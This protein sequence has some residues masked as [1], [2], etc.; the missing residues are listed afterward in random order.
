[1]TI[2]NLINE[3]K[4]YF[5]DVQL[6]S[7]L[8]QAVV[9][10]T[11]TDFESSKKALAVQQVNGRLDEAYQFAIAK[12]V[13]TFI[14]E[15][16]DEEATSYIAQVEITDNDAATNLEEIN[17]SVETTSEVEEV[18]ASAKKGPKGPYFDHVGREYHSLKR[19]CDDYGVTPYIYKKRLE[20]GWSLEATLT[21]PLKTKETFVT[22]DA[23]DDVSENLE[24][25]SDAKV[26]VENSI[27]ADTFPEIPNDLTGEGAENAIEMEAASSV[28]VASEEE[29]SVKIPEDHSNDE[30]IASTEEVPNAED[31]AEE[32]EGAIP[33]SNSDDDDFVMD[34]IVGHAPFKVSESIEKIKKGNTQELK[35]FEMIK[36]SNLALERRG[37]QSPIYTQTKAYLR[38]AKNH[39]VEV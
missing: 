32:T 31:S 8:N 34:A 4:K 17:V 28:E 10:A 5:I 27:N 13:A 22:E 38:Y 29:V 19:M 15:A 1:M 7:A 3:S 35:L 39:G 36:K 11:C 26:A 37:V 25:F 20:L 2:A 30:N 24:H 33:D 9:V 21:T 18:S 14:D 6:Q 16:V 23:E 12:A